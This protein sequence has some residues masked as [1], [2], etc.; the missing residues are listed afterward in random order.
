MADKQSLVLLPGLLNDA[1]LWDHQIR[2]LSPLMDV[3]VADLS[4][5]DT[6]QALAARTLETAPKSFALCGLSMGGYVAF[7]IMRQAPERVTH[8]ILM[9]TSANPDTPEQTARR[10]DLVRIAQTGRFKGVTPRLLPSLLARES[11]VNR[12]ITHKLMEMAERMGRDVYVRQQSAIMSRAD[13]R[14]TLLTIKIP[15]L[16]LVGREDR[17]TPVPLA[18]EMARAIPHSIL[19]VLDG[20]G[21]LPPIEQENVVTRLIKFFLKSSGNT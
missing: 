6:M 17:L 21:H 12:S 11:L 3:T 4:R 7:E 18:E 2:H 13:S 5:D 14:P 15:T 19:R 20:A 1:M 16:I 8:L 10:R 9:D